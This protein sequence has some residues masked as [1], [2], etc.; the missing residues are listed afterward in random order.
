MEGCWKELQAGGDAGSE[1]GPSDPSLSWDSP[2]ESD[3][4]TI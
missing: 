2:M 3:Q 1:A 4:F